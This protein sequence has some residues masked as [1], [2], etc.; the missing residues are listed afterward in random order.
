MHPLALQRF[1]D[2]DPVERINVE[3]YWTFRAEAIPPEQ[4]N[5][6]EDEHLI[7]V[8][9]IMTDKDGGTPS[10]HGEPFLLLVQPGDLLGHVKQRIQVS[11]CCWRDSSPFGTAL[12]LAPIPACWI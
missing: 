7:T 11:R 5:C 1:D 8:Q 6:H 12:E 4:Q 10:V 3:N 2:T 9:H